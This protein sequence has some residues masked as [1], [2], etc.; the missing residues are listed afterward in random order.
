M[1]LTADDLRK[2]EELLDKK[3]KQELT[4]IRE[5]QRFILEKLAT[6]EERLN[7]VPTREVVEE[8]VDKK[9]EPIKEDLIELKSN[10]GKILKRLNTEHKTKY[11]QIERNSDDIAINKTNIWKNTEE[12]KVIKKEFNT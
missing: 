8:I 4:P 10:V 9:I 5:N 12:I 11:A 2:I 1:S 3:F 6:H 7:K